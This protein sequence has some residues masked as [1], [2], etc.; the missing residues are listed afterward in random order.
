MGEG[1]IKL[2][3]SILDSWIYQN[4]RYF[5]W[6]VAILLNVNHV[7]RRFP[8]DGAVLVCNA[9]ES[10]RSLDD[11]SR[12][13]KCSKK[14]VVKFFELLKS[15]EMITTKIAGK[16][17]R[18]KHLLIVNN[19]C[20]YQQLETENCHS[21]KLKT[22]L[23]GNRKVPSNN[24]DN[25]E[26]NILSSKITFE[27]FWIAYDKKVGDRTKIERKWNLLPIT[28]QKQ[29]MEF[30]PKYKEARPE[31][32][33]RKDPS[34]FLNQKTWNDELILPRKTQVEPK[35]TEPIEW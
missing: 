29:I 18:R 6:W 16:G 7:Q 2:H 4:D 5:R 28:D 21:T 25:N 13:F 32:Q 34:T 3:R 8:A 14:T 12:I 19:W 23:N 11:W 10:F 27:E 1:W 15:D 33:Y 30:I 9:G 17:N 22:S 24:N 31:K 20:K 26:R 35:I